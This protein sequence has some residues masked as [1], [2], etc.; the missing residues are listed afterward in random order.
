M[1]PT[2]ILRRMIVVTSIFVRGFEFTNGGLV[3]DVRPTWRKP[4]CSCCQRSC[5]GY[6][7]QASRL[8]RHLSLGSLRIW[9]RYAP[10]RA[11]C[12][13]CKVTRVEH[14]P[15]AHPNTGFTTAF[16]ELCAYLAQIT[17]WTSTTKLLGIDWRT[18]GVIIGRV[19]DRKLD[20]CRLK[21]LRRIGVDEFSYRKRHRYITIIIDHDTRR[22]V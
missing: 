21:G 17:D 5:P 7:T 2:T 4:R 1:R 10:R 20:P 11:H 15:W 14:L 12:K 18:V 13:H 9:L 22:V 8:W 16:E 6:D 3:I 19:V